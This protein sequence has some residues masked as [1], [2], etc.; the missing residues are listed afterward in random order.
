M[1]VYIVGMAA[2]VVEMGS[3]TLLLR[4][5]A[6]ALRTNVLALGFSLAVSVAGALQL[7]LPGAALGS[8]LAVYLDRTV[9][10][11]RVARRTGIPF[12][13]VQDW[14]ALAVSLAAAAF[15]AA[16][17][18]FLVHR[19]LGEAAPLARVAAGAAILAAAYG[20]LNLRRGL[21]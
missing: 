8:V 5:G 6:F 13:Q 12:S 1:R 11:R 9:M 10:L 15:A 7:G 20:L 17:A 4:E 16:L 18:W 21:R 14:R 19:F 3:I 2:M